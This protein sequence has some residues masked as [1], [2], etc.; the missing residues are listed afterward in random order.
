VLAPLES[1]EI[2][3]KKYMKIQMIKEGRG[4]GRILLYKE[5]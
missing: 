1:D 5:I 4:G 3:A 2:L